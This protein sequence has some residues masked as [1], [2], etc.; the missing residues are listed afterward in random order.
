MPPFNGMSLNPIAHEY[1]RASLKDK[2]GVLEG[3]FVITGVQK[4]VLV[5]PRRLFQSAVR[6]DTPPNLVLEYQHTEFFKLFAQLFDVVA[7]EPVGNI[8]VRPVVEHVKRAGDVDFERR[9][10]PLRFRLRLFAEQVVQVLQYRHLN[11]LWIRE[12]VAVDKPDTTV[13]DG[14]F[15]RFKPH[16]A[17]DNEF[18]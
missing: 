1:I 10:D 5:K 9:R 17:A 15:H 18:A 3:V 6:R 11:G 2:Y 16:F 13:D 14:F 12:V 7:D 4:L 8:H